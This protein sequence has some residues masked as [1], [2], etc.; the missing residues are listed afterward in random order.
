MK[1]KTTVIRL[2][3]FNEDF[4]INTAVSVLKKKGIVIYPTETLYGIGCDATNKKHIKKIFKIK[5]CKPSKKFISAVS[6]ISMAK[7]YFK[8]GNDAEKLIKKFMPG[9]LTII[10][11]N[12]N[13]FR[14]P[15]DMIALK[16]IKKFG[17]PITSTSANISEHEPIYKIHDIVKTFTGKVDLIIDAGDIPKRAA[18]TVFDTK[19]QEIIRQGPITKEE[20]MKVLDEKDK[21]VVLCG[22]CFNKTH[23]GHKYFL[24]TAKSFGRLIVVLTNDRNNRKPYAIPATKRRANLKRLEIADEIIVGDENDCTKVIEKYKPDIVV[25]GY[26]QKLDEKTEQEIRRM[27]IK[28]VRVKKYKDFSTRKM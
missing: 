23:S 26:D 21:T 9:P 7:R 15:K 1:I 22:G 6:D 14:M 25:L 16:I 18:S 27:K 4:V 10:D 20:I 2:Q 11:E 24:K 5:Q 19:T 12:G 3:K 17:K 8:V 13:S 28:I